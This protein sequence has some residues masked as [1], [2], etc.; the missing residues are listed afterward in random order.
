MNCPAQLCNYVGCP[1][2]PQ[3]SLR[4]VVE[5]CGKCSVKFVNKTSGETVDCG[6]GK[7]KVC[8]SPGCVR[9]EMSRKFSMLENDH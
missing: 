6:P 1:D 4:C 9:G 5:S 7:C 8:P 2:Q 3:E